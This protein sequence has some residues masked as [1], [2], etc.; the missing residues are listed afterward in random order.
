M[1]LEDDVLS[2]D[3]GADGAAAI[4]EDKHHI[5][6]GNALGEVPSDIEERF[7]GSKLHV[8]VVEEG[9]YVVVLLGIVGELDGNGHIFV[10]EKR[11]AEAVLLVCR[12][13]DVALELGLGHPFAAA[14]TLGNGHFD[15][16]AGSDFVLG[17]KA[18]APVSGRIPQLGLKT[19][20]LPEVG[21]A[22]QIVGC[23]IQRF[24]GRLF[25]SGS[26]NAVLRLED[27]LP[28]DLAF[29][30]WY[31]DQSGLS[32]LFYVQARRSGEYLRTRHVGEEDAGRE[33]DIVA[34][35]V[36]AEGIGGFLP[37][38][39][40]VIVGG[41][42]SGVSVPVGQITGFP[43]AIHQTVRTRIEDIFSVLEEGQLVVRDS[44]SVFVVRSCAPPLGRIAKPASA[45]HISGSVIV[46][47]PGFAVVTEER[48]GGADN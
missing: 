38:G 23:R 4:V 30:V 11:D 22:V 36:G 48:I 3:G 41:T 37:L 39:G 20:A 25:G 2:F 15:A 46:Q 26:G 44:E 40:S 16:V 14:H 17:I 28:G 47:N 12:R 35:C 10:C 21:I 42:V 29:E 9:V 6:T 1:L 31:E 19:G 43:V 13:S 18:A 32:H 8:A 45:A 33:F 24:H 7:A 34:V 27:E 5:V